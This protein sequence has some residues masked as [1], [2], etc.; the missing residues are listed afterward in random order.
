MPENKASKKGT[1]VLILVVAL[2]GGIYAIRMTVAF[3]ILTIGFLGG[4]HEEASDIANYDKT[5][6]VENNWSDMDSLFLIFP[7]DTSKIKRE[8]LIRMLNRI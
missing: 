6:I 8:I 4:N 2:L 3:L 7:D 1:K 5:K